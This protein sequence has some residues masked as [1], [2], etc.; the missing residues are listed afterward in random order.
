MLISHFVSMIF[1]QLSPTKSKS[2]KTKLWNSYT[3]FTLKWQNHILKVMIVNHIKKGQDDSL[4]MSRWILRKIYNVQY[5]FFL[6]KLTK[7]N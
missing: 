4:S 2:L 6:K 5:N 3:T 1:K 7:S